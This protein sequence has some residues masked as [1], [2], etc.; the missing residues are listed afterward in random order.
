[1]DRKE[2][3]KECVKINSKKKKWVSF[4]ELL[5]AFIRD[6]PLGVMRV[7]YDL[8]EPE[9]PSESS[10]QEDSPEHHTGSELPKPSAS[11]PPEV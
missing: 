2:Y 11:P 1:M 8:N 7:G 6:T 5:Y 3:Y 4:E 10:A 9:T